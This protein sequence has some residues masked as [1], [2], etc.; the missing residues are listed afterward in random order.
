MEWIKLAYLKLRM[1]IL[2]LEIYVIRGLTN[3]ITQ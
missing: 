1:A 3:L 2:R